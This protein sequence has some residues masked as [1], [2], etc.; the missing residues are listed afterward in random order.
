VTLVGSQFMIYVVAKK[1][2]SQ[3]LRGMCAWEGVTVPPRLYG[4]A[5]SQLNHSV[6]GHMDETHGERSQLP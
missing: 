3:Y 4:D 1:A 6:D 2:S 5:F